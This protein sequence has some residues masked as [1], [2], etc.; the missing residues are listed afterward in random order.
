VISTRWSTGNSHLQLQPPEPA[1]RFEV[2][3][4]PQPLLERPAVLLGAALVTGIAIGMLVKW[5]F[6]R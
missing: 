4:P 2:V 6:R 3:K 1:P 5:G